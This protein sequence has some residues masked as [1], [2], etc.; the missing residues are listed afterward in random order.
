MD[1][2]CIKTRYCYFQFTGLMKNDWVCFK[3]NWIVISWNVAGEIRLNSH[4]VANWSTSPTCNSYG[5]TME[6]S[7]S[8]CTL[9]DR[10]VCCAN[11]SGKITYTPCWPKL[12]VQ[13][14]SLQ[15]EAILLGGY[16]VTSS[17]LDWE[18]QHDR[19]CCSSSDSECIVAAFSSWKLIF[20]WINIEVIL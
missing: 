17:V 4:Q 20:R 18:L 11:V 9:S 2:T 5:T 15:L 3:Q 6:R 8:D 14:R 10:L 13:L 16:P 7:F 12:D 1:I 19:A